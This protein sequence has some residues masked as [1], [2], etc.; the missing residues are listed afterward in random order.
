M[1]FVLPSVYFPVSALSQGCHV[2]THETLS[3]TPHVCSRQANF[4]KRIINHIGNALL[5][6]G[7]E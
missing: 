1:S 5:E 4:K 7:S 6:Q 3:N 2:I